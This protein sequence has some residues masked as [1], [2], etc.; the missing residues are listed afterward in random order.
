MIKMVIRDVK[1][2][3]AVDLKINKKAESWKFLGSFSAI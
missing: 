2:Y 3:A 1:R